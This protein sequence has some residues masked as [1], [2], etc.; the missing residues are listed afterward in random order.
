LRVD[1]VFRR[2]RS[3][4][5][6]SQRA[7]N[8][9]V[10]MLLAGLLTTCRPAP[11]A[12]R[13][14]L[15]SG[16]TAD[17]P[18]YGNDPG[19]GRYSPLTQ[20]TRDNVGTLTVA[21]T[22]HTGDL[23]D[24]RVAR[25]G[26]KPRFEATPILVDGTLYL[27]SIYNRV[28]ALDPE[29]GSARWT[30]DPHLDL[31][32]DDL[33]D[34]AVRGVSTWLDPN[35]G[36]TEP[37][38]RRIF[39]ATL[40]SRLIALDARTG[41]PCA[42]FG[43]AGQ[44]DLFQDVP[45]EGTRNDYAETSPPAIIDDLVVVGAAIGDNR[46][47]DIKRGIIRA[48]DARHGTERWRF[49]PIQ[50]DPAGQAWE[51]EAA[52][53]TGG[54][55]VWSIISADRQRDLLFLPTE[56]A[57]VDF[58]GGAR[59][60]RNDDADSVIALR[61]STGTPVW[62]F[63]AV[64]H[65]LWDY[66]LP[67]MPALVTIHRDGQD[68]PA[69]VQATKMGH[70]FILNRETGES[71]FPIEERPV[72]ASDVQGEQAWPTQPFPVAPAPLVP[73]SL[74]P[75][76]AYGILPWDREACRQQLAALRHDGIFTPPSVQGTL[77]FPG[78]IGG[79][80]W[81]GV[82]TDPE[83]GLLVVNTNTV[84]RAVWLIPRDQLAAEQ[85]AHPNSEIAAQV[86][87]PYGLRRE[88]LLSPIGLPCNPPPWGRL[89][90][91]DLA[92]GEKRW[93]VPLGTLE[94]RMPGPLAALMGQVGTPNLGGSVVTASGLVFIG[95]ALDNFIRAFD[96]ETGRELWQAQLPAGGQAAPMTYRLSPGGKQYVVIAAGGSG[97]LGTTLGDAVVA[98]S[99]P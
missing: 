91:I 34:P 16:P 48:F 49:D 41:T 36:A 42:D 25:W 64:H 37:C 14:E 7:L 24:Q 12:T 82:S 32:L 4:R 46:R 84:A 20:I 57:S 54:A 53:R 92:S 72:P 51:G 43:V 77:L 47:T 19:G 50:T 56:S 73:Q 61:A 9:G 1:S 38:Q 63:Q 68:I 65:D 87:T 62:H 26:T 99:L 69:I 94:G 8:V 15:A 95:A 89:V 10:L 52:A 18:A 74:T 60:G 44:V 21:W 11:S 58:Y 3:R 97:N 17:W 31:S 80:N 22:Y 40:D 30:Y 66:D 79:A 28:I 93:E 75:D 59:P 76:Q 29:T 23:A 55:G 13:P 5:T 90:A 96:V 33:G 2:D 45:G 88:T 81:S 6:A 78:D 86:G 35:R 39:V 70:L 27:E 71:L 67:A 98:F 83:L 85:A